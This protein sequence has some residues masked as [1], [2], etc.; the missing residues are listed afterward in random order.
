MRFLLRPET[1]R[2]AFARVFMMMGTVLLIVSGLF[3]WREGGPG[4]G[5][6]IAA[7][8]G[9]TLIFFATRLFRSRFF[10]DVDERARS[11]SFIEEGRLQRQFT[12]PELGPLEISHRVMTMR[13]KDGSQRTIDI[14]DVR[15]GRHRDVI[16]R[17]FPSER[18]ARRFA[19]SMARTLNLPVQSLSGEIRGA[20]ELDAPLYVR[21]RGDSAASTPAIRPAD[22]D[23]DVVNLSPG[24]EITTR[25]RSRRPLLWA[26]AAGVIPALVFS[27]L[28]S[29]FGVLSRLREGRIEGDDWLLIGMTV[30]CFVPV[31]IGVARGAR[32]AFAPG[33]IVVT[34]EE[35]RYR[36]IRV[37]IEAIEEIDGFPER[38][39]RLVTDRGILEISRY[40]C[41]EADRS[42]LHHELRRCVVEMGRR[43]RMLN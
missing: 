24:Y 6:L 43:A 17:E 15:S 12:L 23:L 36:R 13:R 1:A 31:L 2:R 41:N 32:E 35:V 11:V 37:P 38:T 9:S 20:G 25:Y 5:A 19:E 26:L 10:I 34:P 30:V 21:L 8:L 39:P 3:I 18:K 27:W 33:R 28:G 16:F 14:Y 7:A 4:P 22:S 29:R 40:F 42:F